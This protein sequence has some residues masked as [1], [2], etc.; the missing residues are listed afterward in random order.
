MAAATEK[1]GICVNGMS[2]YR[3]DGVNAN[4]AVLVGVGPE[5]FGSAHPLAGVAFQ[6]KLEADAY[7]LGGGEYRARPSLQ[8][9]FSRA[10]RL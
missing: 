9:I 6:R 4:S 2:R 5:D 10:S 3:R 7:R 8:G 1:G